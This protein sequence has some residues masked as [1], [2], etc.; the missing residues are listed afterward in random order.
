M[1]STEKTVGSFHSPVIYE[2]GK[3]KNN[4]KKIRDL[5]FID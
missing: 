1:E 5:A 4:N 3:S 2:T